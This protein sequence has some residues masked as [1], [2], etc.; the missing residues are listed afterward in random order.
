MAW[1]R[2]TD[3]PGAG[4]TPATPPRNHGATGIGDQ[5]YVNGGFL[6][7]EFGLPVTDNTWNYDEPS[8]TWTA[9]AAMPAERAEHG[10]AAVG[11]KVYVAGGRDQL[12]NTKNTLFEYNPATNT[13]ATKAN[14]PSA[15]RDAA[16]V[17][18]GTKLYVIGGSDATSTLRNTLY[19][20]NQGTNTWTA[21]SM[22]PTALW[23][24][25][26]AVVGTDIFVFGGQDSSPAY[27]DTVYKWNQ[28]T[29]TW[30]TMSSTM[31][32]A[33]GP[34]G[35]AV[36]RGTDVL[37]CGGQAGGIDDPVG[38]NLDKSN[39]YKY[40]TLT[41]SWSTLDPLPVFR[42]VVSNAGTSSFFYVVAGWS[43][44]Q[45]FDTL[46]RWTASSADSV[47]WHVGGPHW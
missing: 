27:V 3:I 2:K 35:M 26:A 36:A 13:W 47:D 7:N 43:G 39:L 9:T 25:G 32:V 23:L 30:S 45:T 28:G 17:A 11:S 5:L 22:M 38:G 44:T 6:G 34:Y 10:C 33:D 4:T 41:D 24:M 21:K 42:W 19:E 20:W 16:A 15:R 8:D 40:D 46:Y 14:M 18:I 37:I 12:D 29:D 31:P 1:V